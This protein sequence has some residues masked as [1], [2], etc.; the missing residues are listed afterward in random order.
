MQE[1]LKM[2]PRDTAALAAHLVF[3][4]AM[5]LFAAGQPAEPSRRAVESLLRWLDGGQL[6]EQ[7][8]RPDAG[9]PRG[10]LDSLNAAL[11]EIEGGALVPY[12]APACGG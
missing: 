12:D 11:S 2:Y 3:I 5:L 7:L 8:C 4:R 10:Y 9:R 1:E 6:A